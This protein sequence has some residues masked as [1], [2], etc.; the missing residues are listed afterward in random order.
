M[1]IRLLPTTKLG[2][3]S[4]LLALGMFLFALFGV[5]IQESSHFPAIVA[6]CLGLASAIV[7]V[8]SFLKSKERSVPVALAILLGTAVVVVGLVPGG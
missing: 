8:L 2:L 3:C 6:W 5:I 4:C 7:G 1:N